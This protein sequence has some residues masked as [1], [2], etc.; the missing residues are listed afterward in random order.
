[1]LK[2]A[3]G[4][5]A[6]ILLLIGGIFVVTSPEYSHHSQYSQRAKPPEHKKDC[7]NP[8][9]AFWRWTTHDPVAFYTSVLAIFTGVLS[10]STIGLWVVTWRGGVRQSRDMEA[11]I[12]AAQAANQI[13]RDGIVADQRAWV[14]IGELQVDQ[15]I[16]FDSEGETLVF[17]SV[18]VTNIGKTPALGIHTDMDILFEHLKA[19]EAVKNLGEKNKA[20]DNV[21]WTRILLPGDSYRRQ[22]ALTIKT[23]KDGS[24]HVF[25]IVIGCTTYRITPDKSVHQTGFVFDL[26]ECPPG[27]KQKFKSPITPSR[28]RFRID[29]IGWDAGSGG[30]AD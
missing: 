1:M 24:D 9:C 19:P 4:I 17:V 12:A 21:H 27:K 23:P 5:C 11:A 18:K 10:I 2:R 26:F 20:V 14:K 30:F 15:E 29:Q 22:W 8:F 3:V 6:L 7:E 25:P 16:V 13:S 28:G